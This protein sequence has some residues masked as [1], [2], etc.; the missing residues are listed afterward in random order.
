[1]QVMT[2]LMVSK[3]S[4]GRGIKAIDTLLSYTVLRIEEMN[5]MGTAGI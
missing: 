2:M 5:P 1:M 4:I 3:P